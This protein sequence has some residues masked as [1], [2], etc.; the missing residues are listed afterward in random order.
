MSESLIL[1]GFERLLESE[2]P[3]FEAIIMS[4]PSRQRRLLQAVAREPTDMLLASAY[5]Q[6]HN[7][8]SVGGVQ[9][10]TRRLAELDLIERETDGAPW[11]VVDP[12][13]AR[14]LNRMREERIE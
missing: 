8:G 13:L 2:R 11:R 5:V 10:G 12:M 6:R 9:H 3:V 4:L 14:W 7:L 1:R